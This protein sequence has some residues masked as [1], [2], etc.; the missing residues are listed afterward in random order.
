VMAVAVRMAALVIVVNMRSRW[1]RWRIG[2]VVVMVMVVVMSLAQRW[3]ARGRR[4]DRGLGCRGDR[5]G[6]ARLQR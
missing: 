5:V 6:R 3:Y 2:N 4:E 1:R